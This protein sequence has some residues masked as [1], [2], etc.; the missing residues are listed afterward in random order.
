VQWVAIFLTFQ[1]QARHTD[2][3]TGHAITDPGPVP[4]PA[5]P[6]GV[7]RIVGALVNPVGS[8][9]ESETVTLLNS[10][11]LP[12]R[13]AG[14]KISDRSKNVQSQTGT[15]AA[16]ATVTLPVQPPV[17]LGNK[18]GIITLLDDRDLK[19]DGVSYTEQDAQPEGWTLVF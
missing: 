16:H 2:D 14:W 17:Q 3:V 4:G 19:V 11:P 15:L 1:S 12:D 6:D 10:S 8:A 7:V 13:L 9:P 5:E 18:G